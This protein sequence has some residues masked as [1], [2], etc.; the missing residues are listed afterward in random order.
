MAKFE[1]LN[2][3]WLEALVAVAGSKK[4][5]EAASKMGLSEGTVSKHLEKLEWWLRRPLVFNGSVELTPEGERLV[6]A[7]KQILELLEQAGGPLP[8]TRRAPDERPQKILPVRA[9]TPKNR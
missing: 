2:V 6:A 4:R 5:T 8:P 9:P 7:A 1:G 3:V